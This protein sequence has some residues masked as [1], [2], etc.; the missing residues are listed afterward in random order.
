LGNENPLGDNDI[1]S[2]RTEART[3]SVDLR[4]EIDNFDIIYVNWDNGRDDLRRNAL[5]L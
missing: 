4:N 2:F 3:P 5:L 1:R